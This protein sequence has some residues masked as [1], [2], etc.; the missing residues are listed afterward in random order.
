MALVCYIEE[1]K[2]LFF[3]GVKF[4]IC[5]RPNLLLLF[6]VGLIYLSSLFILFNFVDIYGIFGVFCVSLRCRVPTIKV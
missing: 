5:F 6:N 4:T 3:S 2:L 1:N